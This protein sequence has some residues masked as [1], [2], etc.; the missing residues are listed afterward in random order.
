MKKII[1]G[2]MAGMAFAFSLG[3]AGCATTQKLGQDA[4]AGQQQSVEDSS[5][6]GENAPD[7]EDLSGK[8]DDKIDGKTEGG[9]GAVTDPDQTGPEKT[10]GNA[11]DVENSSGEI[12]E[13][14]DE[15]DEMVGMPNPFI[16]C[17]SLSQAAGKAGF[18]LNTPESVKEG[19][20][21]KSIRVIKN[22]LIEV[23]Y[24]DG[25][26][27]TESADQLRVRKAEG[28]LDISGDF[29]SYEVNRHVNDAGIQV[30]LRGSEKLF[31]VASW[32][33][34]DYTFSITSEKGLS[35]KEILSLVQKIN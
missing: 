22:E 28:N 16:S 31:N 18:S 23:I 14:D 25:K 6:G 3:L 20:S 29:N 33:S 7:N 11:S 30:L 34:G 15:M 24:T 9:E 17:R 35:Q 5:L 4:G 1:L 26:D 32:I 12:S 8:T 10:V 13:E 2:C 27:V 19:L 21:I